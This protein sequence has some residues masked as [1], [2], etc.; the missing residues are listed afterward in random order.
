MKKRLVTKL[1][2]L[3][4][5]SILGPCLVVNAQGSSPGYRIDESFIGPGGNLESSSVNFLF[6]PGQQSVGNAGGDNGGSSNFQV[7]GGSTT[8][9]EP[10][11]TCVLNTSSLNVGALST[12][13]TATAT[14]TFSVLNYTSYGYAVSIIG[15]TPSNGGHNLTPLSSNAA[16]ATGTEQFGINLVANTVPTTFGANPAQ[17]PDNTFSFGDAATNYNTAN[18]YRYGNGETIANAVQSSGQTNYTIAYIVNVAT[19]TPGGQYSG[20]QTVLCTGTY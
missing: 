11:L 3:I 14:A 2:G 1:I 19:T 7:L 16:S 20:N 17:V 18:S 9:S 12:A 15:N 13:T 6:E 10:R 4:I 8:P 5:F